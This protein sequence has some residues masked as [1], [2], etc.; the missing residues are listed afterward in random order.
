MIL[1]LYYIYLT[2]SFY[3]DIKL[4]F[5]ELTSVLRL[6][7]AKGRLNRIFKE[8]TNYSVL[9]LRQAKGRLN[10]ILKG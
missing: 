7:Q 4:I 9:R 10:R 3:R 1:Y 8:L 6:R 2:Q 5:K